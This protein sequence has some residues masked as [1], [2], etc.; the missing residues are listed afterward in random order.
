MC[1]DGSPQLSDARLSLRFRVAVLDDE[2]RGNLGRSALRSSELLDAF[3][4]TD[5]AGR[6]FLDYCA[7][8]RSVGATRAP[9][10]EQARGGQHDL[11]IW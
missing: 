9:S 11:F 1:Q 7:R 3:V 5:R 4:G 6:T 2:T 8:R 10:T